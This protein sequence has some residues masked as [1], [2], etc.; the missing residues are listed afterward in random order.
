MTI[1]YNNLFLITNIKYFFTINFQFFC[2]NF[3]QRAK[4]WLN[5]EILFKKRNFVQK[6]SYTVIIEIHQTS[7][8]FYF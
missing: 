6:A 4:F 2:Q 8:K 1:F 7:M 5:S 3:G